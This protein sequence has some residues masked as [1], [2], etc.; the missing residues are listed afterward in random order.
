MQFIPDFGGFF[1]WKFPNPFW[2]GTQWSEMLENQNLFL[3]FSALN[4]IFQLK[5]PKPILE[6]DPNGT[7][8]NIKKSDFFFLDIFEYFAGV[9]LSFW[10]GFFFPGI[11]QEAS[12]SPSPE[13]SQRLMINRKELLEK[14]GKWQSWFHL[15][16][17]WPRG[18][19]F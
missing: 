18:S 5:I 16:I 4:V 12:P 15:G 13:N 14:P 9:F 10:V 7:T 3:I 8:P 17:P 6:M 19:L 11:L 1:T 2:K